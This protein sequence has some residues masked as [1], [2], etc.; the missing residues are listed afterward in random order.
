MIE[1]ELSFALAHFEI[2]SLQRPGVEA[3]LVAEIIIDHS[4]GGLGSGGD[5]VHA[6][7]GKPV[8]RELRERDSQDVLLY[9]FGILRPTAPFCIRRRTHVSTYKEALPET[10]W[11]V[12]YIMS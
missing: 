3:Q 8:F 5:R 7:P 10:K 11:T 12:R 1:V 9:R 6:G 2:G 4:L